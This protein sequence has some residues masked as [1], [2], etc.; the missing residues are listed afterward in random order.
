M[1]APSP[2]IDDLDKQIFRLSRQINSQTYR[3]LTR[4][5]PPRRAALGGQGSSER[6]LRGLSRK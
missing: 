1:R 3:L 2:S 6:L 4:P 5:S